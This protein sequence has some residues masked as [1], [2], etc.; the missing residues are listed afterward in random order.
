LVKLFVAVTSMSSWPF[1]VSTV[2][3]TAL[4]RCACKAAAT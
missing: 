2:K 1:V 4:P 3:V